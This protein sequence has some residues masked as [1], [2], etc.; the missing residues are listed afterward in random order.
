M[1]ELL[2]QRTTYTFT[3]EALTKQAEVIRKTSNTIIEG[4]MKIGKAF[5]EVKDKELWSKDFDKFEDFA[6]AV[7]YKKSSAYNLIKAYETSS[8]YGLNDFTAGQ[9]Q[10]LRTLEIAEGEEGVKKALETGMIASNMTSKEI[11]KA[12]N[13]HLHPQTEESLVDE[14]ET[15][16]TTE[17]TTEAVKIE[18]PE[19]VLT[20]TVRKLDNRNDYYVNGKL[21]AVSKVSA[22]LE[23]VKKINEIMEA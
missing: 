8:K 16:T 18:E 22:I 19:T 20:I 3:N 11:R 9:C 14:T 7:G 4:A 15:E 17:G 1:N 13:D 12:I 6:L 10:E 5:K 2:I 23:Y 21:L